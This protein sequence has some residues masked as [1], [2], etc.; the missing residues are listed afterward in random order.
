[1][2]PFDYSLG[3]LTILMGLALA[4]VSFSFHKL[5]IRA[6]T[7]RWDGRPLIAAA[8]VTVECVRLWFGQWTL[9]NFSA[10]LTFPIYFGLFVQML[11]LVLLASASLPDEPRDDCDLAVVYEQ[12]RRYFW[13]L[14]AAYH[15]MYFVFWLIFGATNAAGNAPASAVDW[16]R[17]LAPIGA[18]GL[19]A[20]V[21]IGW[22]DY[23][24][25][26]AF[27]VFYVARYWHATLSA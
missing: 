21:R 1:M 24:V 18:F 15:V 25:P 3:L 22:L 9:R 16:V 14:F 11:L 20:L 19:L 17:V 12:R 4:D 8:L 13:G 23:L 27:I 6:R 7:I 10:A 26:A 5:A 2:N